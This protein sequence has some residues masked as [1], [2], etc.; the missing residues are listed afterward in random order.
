MSTPQID[1]IAELLDQL[2]ELMEQQDL[3]MR[4]YLGE[5]T[6][7]DWAADLEINGKRV[8]EIV[9]GEPIDEDDDEDRLKGIYERCAIKEFLPDAEVTQCDWRD[10]VT[11]WIWYVN[12]Q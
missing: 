7:I 8:K 12:K 2:N 6:I 1:Q 9:F 4:Y 5:G 10:D 11:L 3:C